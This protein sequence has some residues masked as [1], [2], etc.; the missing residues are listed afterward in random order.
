MAHLGIEALA[1]P[2]LLAKRPLGRSVLASSYDRRGGNHDWSNYIR[3]E[4][5]AA[6]LMQ[7][8]G[9]GCIT[10]IWTAD[11]Q[12]GA[13]RFYFDRA[14]EPAIEMPFAKLFD[15]L[16]L[17]AGI[18]GEST[19]NYARSTAEHVPMGHSSYC[20]IPFA[21]HVKVTVEPED[22]Y[23]YYHVNAHLFPPDEAV[24]TFDIATSLTAELVNA[25]TQAV[26]GWEMG[27]PLVEMGREARTQIDLG[28]GDEH[29]IAHYEGGGVIRGLR[30]A[31]PPGISKRERAHLLENVWLVAHF[32]DDEP[33]DPSIRVPIGPMFLDYGQEP[34]ART[35]FL[36]QESSGD[37]YCFLP[38][39]HQHR[40]SLKLVNRS[41]LGARLTAAVLHDTTT[42]IDADMRRLRATWHVESPFGPDHRDYDGV[43]CRLLNLDGAG[44]VELLHVPQGAGHFVGCGVSI[45]L[46]DAPTDRAACEGDE[47]FFI[48]DDARL[49]HYGTGFEDYCND[50]WGIR[51]Y[52][53]P[54]AGDAIMQSDNAGPILIGYRL[55]AADPIAFERKGRF[56]LEHGTGN[57]C[58]GIFKSVAYWYM[59][60]AFMR[61][62]VEER[63]W[64]ALL[65]G[66]NPEE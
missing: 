65:N 2:L 5:K 55:H 34:A 6:V 32:D 8:E 38:M 20:P 56:T 13:I 39:P 40:A 57:N 47:M 63:R 49:T 51:G 35:L 1:N 28:L 43:A 29:L 7:A 50:A 52:T 66:R 33:R 3:R 21:K 64:E 4:G 62:R 54:F 44:N 15:F 48:D 60:A 59:D 12:K 10:R 46:S 16:P 22:D 27:M 23:L 53:G 11:P 18:G 24:P 17:S 45:D 31:L 58:S 36:G 14:P 9:P 30:L 42:P 61:T 37:Y 25:A 41:M 26:H 19:Q